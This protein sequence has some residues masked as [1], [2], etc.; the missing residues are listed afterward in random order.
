MNIYNKNEE[1]SAYGYACGYTNRI[2][3]DGVY[4]ELYFEG[5]VYHVRSNVDNDKTW[6]SFETLGK[7]KRFFAKIKI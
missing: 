7:A 3:S 5:G 4:K 1:L 2:E 6:E